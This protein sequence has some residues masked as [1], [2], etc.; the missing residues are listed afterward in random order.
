MWNNNEYKGHIHRL[1]QRKKIY[2]SL[3]EKASLSGK[4][5]VI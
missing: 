4:K 2:Q 5:C 3:D 1:K